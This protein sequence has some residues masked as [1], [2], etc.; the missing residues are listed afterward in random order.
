MSKDDVLNIRED[1]NATSKIVGHFSWNEKP[2]T[3][4]ELSPDKK[5]GPIPSNGDYWLR[6]KYLKPLKFKMFNDT[7]IPVGLTCFTEGPNWRV[8][9]T[10]P[11]QIFFKNSFEEGKPADFYYETKIDGVNTKFVLNTTEDDIILH[12]SERL[13]ETTASAK[14]PY[15]VQGC[16]KKNAFEQN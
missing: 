1:P 10:E 7:R 11:T 9:L 4:S 16:N 8:I 15:S 14:F 13:C 5:C 6:I 2:V 3:I 12:V